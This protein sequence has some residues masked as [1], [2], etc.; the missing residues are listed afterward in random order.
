MML[1]REVVSMLAL[2]P[3]PAGSVRPFGSQSETSREQRS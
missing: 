1:D 3:G 2:A